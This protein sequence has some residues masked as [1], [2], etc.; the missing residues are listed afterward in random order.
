MKWLMLPLM[1]GKPWNGQT[2]HA[3]P[4]GG[5]E[6]AVAY[7]ARALAKKGE[8][9]TVVTHG[10]GC[11]VDDVT[12][13]NNTAGS[14]VGQIPWD[15]VLSSRWPQI[16]T[17]PWKA[18]AR[19]LWFHDLPADREL[20]VADLYVFI[21]EYQKAQY[22]FRE[23]ARS[24]TI[25]DGVDESFLNTSVPE[26]DKTRLIWTSNPDRG[27]P[28]AVKIMKE[29]RKRWPDLELHVFGRSSVYG[30]PDANER[31]FR[32]H[33][34][35]MKECGVILHDPLPRSLLRNELAK[36]WAFFYPT[37]WPETFCMA[38]L[39]A[40][41]CGTPVI[42]SPYG[43]LPETVKGGVLTYD[44]LNAIS[45]LRNARRWEKLSVQGMEFATTQ[46]WD[47]VAD[48]WIKEV[49]NAITKS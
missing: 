38:A 29:V 18:K 34:S 37:T 27:L 6:S 7:L 1:A 33:D 3:E 22:R 20:A 39:E 49:N 5:S 36:S 23:G 15:V 40:Q 2:I 46:T 48:A 13:I 31:P 26:R 16:L 44:F 32:Y 25:G 14:T 21:S 43:A 35:F 11:V 24:A 8:N 41:A 10:T 28:V 30:W 42:A 17:Q 19:V 4:L 45:Q 9:V 47:L 12:Y